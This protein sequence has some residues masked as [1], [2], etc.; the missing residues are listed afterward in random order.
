MYSSELENCKEDIWRQEMKRYDSDWNRTN[1]F[2]IHDREGDCFFWCID[3][4]IYAIQ[5]NDYD[6]QALKILGEMMD[7]WCE[8]HNK[9]QTK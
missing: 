2:E 4:V 6:S 5:Q 3:D 1:H 7:I 8:K 9:E